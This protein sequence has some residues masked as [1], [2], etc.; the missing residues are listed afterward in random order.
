MFFIFASLD[1]REP[2]EIS[3]KILCMFFWIF[4]FCPK[5]FLVLQDKKCTW[6]DIYFL[7]NKFW[8]FPP[9]LQ[10]KDGR[11]VAPVCLE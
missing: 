2:F 8:R 1:F 5:V 9:N 11:V 3:N 7:A 4:E 6:D 10:P